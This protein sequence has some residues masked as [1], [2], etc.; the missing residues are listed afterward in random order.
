MSLRKQGNEHHAPKFQRHKQKAASQ[1]AAF[2]LCFTRHDGA[3]RRRLGNGPQLD[4]CPLPYR[5]NCQRNPMLADQPCSPALP[6][7]VW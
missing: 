3:M 7:F 1:D 4:G 6:V 5:Q 2:C